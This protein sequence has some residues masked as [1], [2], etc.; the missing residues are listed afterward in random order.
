[1]RPDAKLSPPPTRSR[2]Q[3]PLRVSASK[4]FPTAQQIAPQSLTDAL[5][6]ERHVV[7]TTLRFGNSLHPDSIIFLNSPTLIW[8][9]LSPSPS[10]LKPRHAVKSSSLRIITSTGLQI[11]G[12]PSC[13]SFCP[14]LSS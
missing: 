14:P 11:G 1:M 10:I 4:N 9:T 5:F 8:L 12:L 13:A 7:A 2:I 6:T 3:R